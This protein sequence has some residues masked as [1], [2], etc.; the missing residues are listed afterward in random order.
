MRWPPAPRANGVYN[1]GSANSFPTS[2]YN[3]N[4]Y[5]VDV[6][7]NP[8]VPGQVTGVTAT[9]G[10]LA[11]TVSWTAPS[12]GG[13]TSY[14]VT[15]YIGTTAQ[16]PTTVTGNP[17]ATTATIDRA[18]AG[19]RLH[20]HREGR[21]RSGQGH[22][23]R[24]IQFRHALP[25]TAPS[26][27]TGV[28]APPGLGSGPGQLDRPCRQRRRDHGLHDHAVHRHHRADTD[29]GQQRLGDLS[30]VKA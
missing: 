12:G 27:P 7:F 21:Q 25:P 17:P 10:R 1:Y 19:H 22:R 9:A 23:V 29:A 2:T 26:A 6:L 13:A 11:A 4:N 15:P 16:T 24:G 20:L 18:A 5:W 8:S 3:A 28:T 30:D 14:I